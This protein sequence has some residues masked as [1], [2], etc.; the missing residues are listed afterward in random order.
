MDRFVDRLAVLLAR[1]EQGDQAVRTSRRS[2]VRAAVGAIV[3]AAMATLRVEQA[4]AQVCC[5][6][7]SPPFEECRCGTTGAGYECW[8]FSCNYYGLVERGCYERACGK[9]CTQ[10]YEVGGC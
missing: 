5:P 9:Q 3:I 8:M 7:P 6:E 2:A 10:E 1:N 4:E